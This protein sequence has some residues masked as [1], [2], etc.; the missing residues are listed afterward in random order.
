MKKWLA[1]ML[2]LLLA[3]SMMALAGCGDDKKKD[4]KDD[5]KGESVTTTVTDGGT[6]TTVSSAD[7]EMTVTT[8]V[9]T[10]VV[11]P[12][13]PAATVVGKWKSEAIDAGEKMKEEFTD[14]ESGEYYNFGSYVYYEYVEFF[15]DGTCKTYADAQEWK[16]VVEGITR[17][18]TAGM[19]AQLTDMAEEYGISLSE[20]L[21]SME[22]SSVEALV[23]EQMSVFGLE[24][25]A[26]NGMEGTYDANTGVIAVEVLG[27]MVEGHYT[28]A[29]GILSISINGATTEYTKM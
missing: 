27:E 23:E 4:G 2:V 9:Q 19:E 12:D 20:L 15:A 8:T 1:L 22:Y 28:L 3:V 6:V 14:L 5:D 11:T 10:P 29:D 21:E 16:A 13:V 26:T 18:L 25:M 24:D 17:D 7:G